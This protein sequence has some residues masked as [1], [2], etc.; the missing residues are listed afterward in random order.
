[1]LRAV[2]AL[3]EWVRQHVA[4][5][6]REQEFRGGPRLFRRASGSVRAMIQV[7]GSVY[8]AVGPVRFRINYGIVHDGVTQAL[9]GRRPRA[10]AFDINFG[11]GVPVSRG[12]GWW[13][14][15]PPGDRAEKLAAT[16]VE[17]LHREV[18]PF[19]ERYGTGEG[20]REYLL[21]LP[22]DFAGPFLRALDNIDRDNEAN[23]A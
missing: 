6:L 22:P 15:E 1:M 17:D 21:G 18:L 23:P 8:N 3:D 4:P 7:Q 12:G 2:N 5:T 9:S 13:T 16:V 10:S 11:Q 20:Y 19:L 14:L